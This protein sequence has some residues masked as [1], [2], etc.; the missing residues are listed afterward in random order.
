MEILIDFPGGV[1]VNAHF[2]NFTVP[3]DQPVRDGGEGSAPSPFDTFLASIAT[4]AGY[5]VVSYCQ[6]HGLPTEGIQLIQRTN[7]NRETG[8]IDRIEVEIQVPST[9][10]E[11]YIPSLVRSAELCTVKKH[12]E[13][14]PK[15]EVS[16]QVVNP[17]S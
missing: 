10:P 14:P 5:Y 7:R 11:K 17:V 9:F 6:Q 13:H 1:K 4:C 2:S 16:T 12:L 8:L 3:T 15:I